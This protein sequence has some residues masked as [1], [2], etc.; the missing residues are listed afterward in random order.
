MISKINKVCKLFIFLLA[1]SIVHLILPTSLFSQR[2]MVT[3]MTLKVA[4]VILKKYVDNIV[5]EK[6]FA[7]FNFRSYEEAKTATIGD[8]YKVLIIGLRSLKTYVSGSEIKSI[9]K[10]AKKI[11]IPVEV[12]G[13]IRTKME[14]VERRGSW[15]AGE[16]GGIRTVA[17]IAS[18]KNQI[19][20]LIRSKRIREPYEI[21]L[22]QVPSMYAVFFYIDSHQGSYLVPAMIQP[23][24]L[25]LE[26]GRI[27]SANEVLIKLKEFAVKI[28]E[29][30]LM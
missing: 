8:P 22:L 28:D 12:K 15:I 29:D 18:V 11:W 7:K 5:T 23:K 9:L 26:N 24:R 13:E 30:K 1:C 20:H 21:T 27:Y 19:P 6:N 14:L 16:F 10:D 17:E 4:P 3:P 25:N 2:T